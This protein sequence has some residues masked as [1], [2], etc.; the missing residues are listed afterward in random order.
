LTVSEA[1]GIALDRNPDVRSARA[2][3][4][5]ARAAFDAS[6]AALWP[7]LS[8]DLSLLDSDAPSTYLFKS[9]DAHSLAAGTDFNSPGSIQNTEAGLGLSWNLWN[10]GRDRLAREAAQAGVDVQNQ[11]VLATRNSLVMAVV[12]AYLD[13]RA[14]GELLVSDDA[15]LRSIESQLAEVRSRVDQ[16]AALKSDQL[17]LEVRAAEARERRLHT[18]LGQK[19]ALAML[20]NLLALDGDVPIE[21][22][23]E[24]FDPGSLPGSLTAARELAF[25]Q[26]PELSSA[27]HALDRA[28]L[29]T[30]AAWRA[31][32]PRLDLEGRFYAD[33]NDYSFDLQEPNGTIALI[34]SYPL[35]EGGSRSADIARAKANRAEYSEAELR[36]RNAVALEVET[37]WLR[38]EEARERVTVASQALGA[39]QETL[40]L[41]EKQFRSGAA[42]VTRFLEAEAARS[43]V[44]TS[45]IRARLDLERSDVELARAVGSLSGGGG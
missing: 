8:A 1:V 15:S 6:A 33:V 35:F 31:W 30:E 29:E 43:Q 17:S 22:A 25:A 14:A 3:V 37:A 26:R 27:K 7:R 23:P 36:A 24:P 16:G 5:S 21:L 34:L 19:L 4:D 45:L 2:K 20:R 44:E 13:A 12:A 9:I 38:R 11:G 32:L 42:T 10:G 18:Q 39:S 28:E 40:S 41:V